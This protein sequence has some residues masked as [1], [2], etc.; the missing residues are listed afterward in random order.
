MLQNLFA[1]LI[2]VIPS[3][4][5]ADSAHVTP[6]DADSG[7]LLAVRSGNPAGV[8]A[9]LVKGADV[10]LPDKDG[11]SAL[12]FSVMYGYVKAEIVNSLF[13]HGANVNAQTKDGMTALMFASGAGSGGAGVQAVKML[14]DHGADPNI[15]NGSGNT[16]MYFAA[17]D[18]RDGDIEIVKALLNKGADVTKMETAGNSDIA[19]LLRAHGAKELKEVD[20]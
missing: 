11:F 16:A 8:Q 19:N 1:A 17:P 5:Y 3:I 12:M 13:A 20:I 14:L 18:N 9:E 6:A 4:V 2:F 10:N 7:L 15:K